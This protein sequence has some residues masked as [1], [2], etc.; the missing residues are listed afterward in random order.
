MGRFGQRAELRPVVTMVPGAAAPSSCAATAE[1][2][3]QFSGRTW[4]WGDG[5]TPNQ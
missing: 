1:V 4:A 5:T 3:D 2:Y